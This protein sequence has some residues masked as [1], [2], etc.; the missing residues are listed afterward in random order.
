MSKR[1]GKSLPPAATEGGRGPT[2]K[3]GRET[4]PL[5]DRGR[6]APP[7]PRPPRVVTGAF[8]GHEDR[9]CRAWI[10]DLG[11][12]KLEGHLESG[13]LLV[14]GREAVLQSVCIPEGAD[15]FRFIGALRLLALQIEVGMVEDV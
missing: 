2:V 11:A 5:Q 14:V 4:G 6:S 3:A 10:G 1:P 8:G 12:T 9:E 13:V 15:R 7:G